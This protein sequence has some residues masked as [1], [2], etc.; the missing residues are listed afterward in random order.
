MN[1]FPAEPL[2]TL[3][4]NDAE[5]DFDNWPAAWVRISLPPPQNGQACL[6]AK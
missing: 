3:L 5:F 2:Y 1:D 4:V 6:T